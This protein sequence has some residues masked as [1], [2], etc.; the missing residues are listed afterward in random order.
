[1]VK[2]L[3]NY[4][5]RYAENVIQALSHISW[6]SPGLIIASADLA[7]LLQLQ[8]ANSGNIPIILMTSLLMEDSTSSELKVLAKIPK[9]IDPVNLQ[10]VVGFALLSRITWKASERKFA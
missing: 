7:G 6:E 8:V 3:V 10:S 5:V 4:N 9:P 2:I 1:M